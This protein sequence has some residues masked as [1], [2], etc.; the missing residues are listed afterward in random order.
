MQ[1]TVLLPQDV[2]M[3]FMIFSE[4]EVARN[5]VQNSWMPSPEL[6]PCAHLQLKRVCCSSALELNHIVLSL[7]IPIPDL[8][9]RA[10][11][12]SIVKNRFQDF[13]LL[14]TQYLNQVLSLTAIYFSS[15][16]Q[17]AKPSTQ[18]SVPS[19]SISSIIPVEYIQQLL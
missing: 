15:Q 14:R 19:Q 1:F 11:P 7:R 3:T 5:T 17:N 2:Q 12:G 9:S 13:H 4:R 18:H 8:V 16:I 6:S 10:A